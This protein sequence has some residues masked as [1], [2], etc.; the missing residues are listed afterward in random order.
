M[1]AARLMTA[2]GMAAFADHQ[3]YLAPKLP[4]RL[5]QALQQ[6]FRTTREAWKNFEKFP[7][8][9][10]RMTIGW[11]ASAKKAQTQEQRLAKLIASAERNERL[12]FI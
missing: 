9:Y 10:K 2:A 4:T 3:K 5:P 11:V 1:I 7:P 6:R 12:K 8:G